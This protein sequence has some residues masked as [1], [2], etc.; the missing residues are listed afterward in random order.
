MGLLK[1]KGIGY[2]GITHKSSLENEK[3]GRIHPDLKPAED[4]EKTPEKPDKKK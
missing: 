2:P 4:V 1:S 3:E